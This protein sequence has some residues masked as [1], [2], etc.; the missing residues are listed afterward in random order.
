MSRLR[1]AMGIR[2]HYS[3][4]IMNQ[5]PLF[6]KSRRGKYFIKIPPLHW[7]RFTKPPPRGMW[8]FTPLPFTGALWGFAPFPFAG[9][10][11]GLRPIPHQ[12]FLKKSLDQK[13]FEAYDFVFGTLFREKGF[14]AS[15]KAFSWILSIFLQ[16]RKA[17]IS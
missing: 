10:F 3:V 15:Q 13:T 8:G 4:S 5:M 12:T 1:A 14:Q 17:N 2:F 16:E 11:M 6:V 9:S 7:I